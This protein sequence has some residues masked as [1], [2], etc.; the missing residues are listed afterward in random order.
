MVLFLSLS[1][2]LCDSLLVRPALCAAVWELLCHHVRRLLSW[3]ASDRGRDLREY[4]C[5]LDLWHKEVR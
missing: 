1:G 5:G 4:L 3:F 2:L